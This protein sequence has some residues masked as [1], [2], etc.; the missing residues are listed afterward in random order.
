MATK[1]PTKQPCKTPLSRWLVKNDV[2][3][4]EFAEMLGFYRGAPVEQS[5]VSLWANGHKHPSASTRAM[6]EQATDGAIEAS[7]W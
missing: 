4:L 6:I 1:T 7:A 2:R 5:Q 3:Q